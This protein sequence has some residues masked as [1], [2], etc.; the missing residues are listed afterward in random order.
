MK[1]LEKC[2]YMLEAILKGEVQKNA[3]YYDIP[4]FSLRPPHLHLS[5]A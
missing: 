2:G 5:G 1:V 4:H 3:V